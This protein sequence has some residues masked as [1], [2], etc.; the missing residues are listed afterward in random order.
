MTSGLCFLC[1]PKDFQSNRRHEEN[2]KA[3]SQTAGTVVVELILD[4]RSDAI[5]GY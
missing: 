2:N 5:G 4:E 3:A 1:A